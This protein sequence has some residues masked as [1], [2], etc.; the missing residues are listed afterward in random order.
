LAAQVVAAEGVDVR[1]RAGDARERGVVGDD[2][3]LGRVEGSIEAV[4]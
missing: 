1:V 4:M 3:G 2:V